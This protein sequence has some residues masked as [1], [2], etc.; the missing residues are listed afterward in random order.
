MLELRNAI[1][2][3]VQVY[4]HKATVIYSF[5]SGIFLLLSYIAL[6]GS[7][8]AGLSDV[9]SK[10]QSQMSPEASTT[11]SGYDSASTD[12]D[13]TENNIHN[14]PASNTTTLEKT[15]T[16]YDNSNLD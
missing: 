7:L 13:D 5:Y 16:S 10:L 3:T 2:I 1:Y 14:P 15:T 8:E 4:Y 11:S 6:G 12:K 9:K